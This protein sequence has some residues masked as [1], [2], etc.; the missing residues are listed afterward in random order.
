MGELESL[1]DAVARISKILNELGIDHSVEIRAKKPDDNHQ[2]SMNNRIR[3]G[4]DKDSCLC[5]VEDRDIEWHLRVA[6]ENVAKS[7]PKWGERDKEWQ[8]AVQAEWDRRGL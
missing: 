5:E 1:K 6:K 4:K 3:F 8:D 2:C 7:D